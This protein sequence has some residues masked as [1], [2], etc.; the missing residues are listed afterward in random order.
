MKKLYLAAYIFIITVFLCGCNNKRTQEIEFTTWGSK[1]EIAIIEP[2]AAEYNKTHDVKVRL[3]HIPQNYFQ[4]LHLL[5]ASKL[6]PDVI[7]INNLYLKTYQKANLL[8][9]L[10][11]YINKNEYFKNALYTMSI[12]NKI[13]AVPRDVSNFVI[14][15]NKDIFNKAK[16]KPDKN[17]DINKFYE[18]AKELKKYSDIG[19]CTEFNPVSWGN[20]VSI[21]NKPLFLNAELTINEKKSL[22]AIQKLADKINKENLGANKEQLVLSP[23]AQLFLNKKTPI[24]VSGRWSVPKIDSQAEFEYGVLPFPKGESQYYIPLDSSGWAV[25]KNSKNK[26]AA[27]DFVKYISSD[28][29]IKKIT[30]SGLITPAKKNAANSKEFK[31][32]EV[33]IDIIE[34]STPNIVP[35]NYNIIIDKINTEVMSVLGGYKKAKDI[36]M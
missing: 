24:F 35:S 17:W 34:K 27:I 19:F 4:K 9:D 33:F 31:N 11:P 22:I 18:T 36:K 26:K 1:A 30:E 28:K 8:E 23:C 32:G 3:I 10:T 29:N 5:F 20:F 15:Y 7:F 14:F 25:Y 13:Y 21:E 16:I 2:I 12:D 6:A